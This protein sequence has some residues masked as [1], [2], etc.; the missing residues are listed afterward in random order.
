MVADWTG[1]AAEAYQNAQRAWD[2]AAKDF[3]E[4]LQA[5]GVAVR[6]RARA[7]RAPR[8]GQEA[9][10]LR[11]SSRP[12]AVP[13]D[14]GTSRPGVHVCVPTTRFDPH[15]CGRVSSFFVVR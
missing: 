11:L 4:T 8:V 6:R 14:P 5:I 1:E 12:F 15:G 7:T 13:V 3:Q 2:A 9:L 10:G